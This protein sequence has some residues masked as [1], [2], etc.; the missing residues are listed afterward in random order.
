MFDNK[1]RY[2]KEVPY[3]VKDRKG[4]KVL[5]VPVP[6]PPLQN[7][8]GHHLLLQGQRIDHLADQYLNHATGFW[9]IAAINDVML[10]ETLTEQ[11]EIAIP[12]K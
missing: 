9:R 3:Q 5:V 10:P 12:V 8:S 1:S 4:R 7:L 11:K 6:P 2:R